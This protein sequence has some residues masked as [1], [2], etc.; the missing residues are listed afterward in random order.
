MYLRVVVCS[1]MHCAVL[2]FG[3]VCVSINS[4]GAVHGPWAADIGA[5]AVAMAAAHTHY[6]LQS[7]NLWCQQLCA[8]GAA[9]GHAFECAY[10]IECESF[11]RVDIMCFCD[12]TQHT[13]V[14]IQ[15]SGR[16]CAKGTL[17]IPSMT[18][19]VRVVAGGHISPPVWWNAMD[20]TDDVRTLGRGT[21]IC[22]P[23]MHM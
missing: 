22:M 2:T 8:G 10:A 16:L 9:V 5:Y 15:C 3:D 6:Q 1:I 18:R 23:C 4:D 19:I 17:Q 7:N 11:G 21:H 12:D 14:T 13:A 20:N